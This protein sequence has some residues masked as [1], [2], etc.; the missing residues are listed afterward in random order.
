MQFTRYALVAL[1]LSLVALTSSA[2]ACDTPVA[3]CERGASS[4]LQI[5]GG[6]EV[7]VVV[8]PS[9]AA[10]VR[11]AAE[12]LVADIERIGGSA[13]L[14]T[15]ISAAENQPTI[16][17]GE[18]GTAGALN[19]ALRARGHGDADFA[20]RWEAYR[21]IML[22]SQRAE[23]PPVL[24]ISGSD[25]RGVI[26]G[27]YDLSERMGVSPWHWWADV[28]TELRQELWLTAGE[29][30]DAP[31]VRYRGFF[32][33]DEEPA[34]GN[35][36]REQFG[37]INAAAYER[38]FDL[39]LRLKGNYIWPAMWGKSLAEDDP[40]SLA[41]AADMGVVLGT[42]HHEPLTRAHVEWERAKHAGTASGAWNYG[43]N[44]E[45]LRQFWGEGM[46]RFNASGADGVVT[47]G[48]RG[49]GDEAM[50]EDTAIPLLEQVVADQRAI[51]A[52]TTG[53]PAAETPQVWALYKEVQDYYDQGMQ[54]PED[55]TLLFADDN[56]GQIRRL[57]DPEAAPRK[58]GYGVYYHFDYVGVPRS[59]K[60]IDTIQNGKTW[61]QMD[62]AWQR[63]ARDLWIVNVGD[64]KP[65]EAPLDFFLDMAWN[66]PAM[67]PD[68]LGDW[69][70]RWAHQQFGA[71]HGAE[72]GSILEEYARLASRRKPELLDADAL[73]PAELSAAVRE[74]EALE[75]RATNMAQA[76]PQSHRAAFGQ[77]VL[78]RVLAVGNLYRLYDAVA[79]NR[80]Q[81]A[82]NSTGANAAAKDAE[83]AFSFDAMLTDL[84]HRTSGG[85]WNHMM[86]QPHI[87]YSSWDDPDESIMPEVTRVGDDARPVAIIP[88]PRL[89]KVVPASEAATR[90]DH[91][92]LSWRLVP[93]LG[94]HGSA[95][96]SLP[97]GVPPTS[98]TDAIVAEFAI[99]A[100]I[101]GDYRIEVALSPT[102]NTL[103][104]E[105]MR[106]GV[107]VDDGP[108]E[109]LTFDL[110]ATGTEQDTPEKRAWAQAV[111]D[112]LVRLETV[113]SD[114]A[115][116]KHRLKLYRIDDN[117]VIDHVRYEP[118][119]IAN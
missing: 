49:D 35:W 64:I 103:G 90:S 107:Q 88:P 44:G 66:P 5:V 60:W 79:R 11:R 69:S 78:H 67:T 63:G 47:I 2:H 13:R 91:Q 50:S 104:G 6:G 96:V 39:L 61:Q 30:G 74:W 7:V 32:I 22:P 18:A 101:A 23:A 111:I 109:I 93:S 108:V 92:A 33:N 70:E 85:K 27:V 105:P 21:Q 72:I 15:S 37:G 99:E 73:P 48:M 28:P 54:V 116:G 58:G 52:E 43:E 53:A 97:Q 84:Y 1:A 56:W 16:W 71:E 4:S 26:Y 89:G 115:R 17:I 8:D 19:D 117:V 55:V 20:G 75:K 95:L 113:T 10:P 65:T 106:I 12:A 34:F 80:R 119:P 3:P 114:L 59:Y 68:A 46:E 77:L 9:E 82:A 118:A 86:S 102:L 14:A 76:L 87:G 83:Q 57:P 112:N 98:A 81:A 51:I 110:E 41:L 94:R 100:V 45:V 25:P 40:A 38:V 62:L 24:A 29:R 42:S 31:Q 36:A